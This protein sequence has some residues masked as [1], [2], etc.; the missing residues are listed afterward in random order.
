MNNVIIQ[1]RK[2]II[3]AN[4][5]QALYFCEQSLEKY[6]ILYSILI[7]DHVFRISMISN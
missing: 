4:S 5:V 3:A 6:C 2:V 1:D 7:D